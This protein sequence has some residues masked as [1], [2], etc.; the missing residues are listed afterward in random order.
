MWLSLRHACEICGVCVFSRHQCVCPRFDKRTW[1]YEWISMLLLHRLMSDRGQAVLLFC[2][3]WTVFV[4]CVCVCVCV[5]A[6]AR[7]NREYSFT[8]FRFM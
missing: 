4:L 1:K 8:T 7:V 3:H 5:R 2:P 6:H